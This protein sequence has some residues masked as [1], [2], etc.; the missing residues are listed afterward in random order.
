MFDLTEDE[1]CPDSDD[2]IVICLDSAETYAELISCTHINMQQTLIVTSLGVHEV[3]NWGFTH[4]AVLTEW[5]EWIWLISVPL[6]VQFVGLSV[7]QFTYSG[8]FFKKSSPKQVFQ[9]QHDCFFLNLY[10]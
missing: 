1:K 5:T 6:S 4:Y 8:L 2:L 10:A 7:S 3:K 9:C